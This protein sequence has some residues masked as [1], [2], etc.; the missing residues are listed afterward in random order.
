MPMKVII[1]P[2]RKV[3]CWPVHTEHGL[4]GGDA[5][6]LSRG[7][8]N[9]PARLPR[10]QGGL[11][12]PA[13]GEGRIR[14]EHEAIEGELAL[15]RLEGPED[16][17]PSDVSRFWVTAEAQREPRQVSAGAGTGETWAVRVLPPYP[18]PDQ[19]QHP[20]DAVGHVG[21][22]VLADPVWSF[23]QTGRVIA[24]S[25]W[26]SQSARC[27]SL[28]SVIVERGLRPALLLHLAP[29][30][31]PRFPQASCR[32]RSRRVCVRPGWCRRPCRRSAAGRSW[33]AF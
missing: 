16:R 2:A 8:L 18:S 25:G 15:P 3:S 24:T 31:L 5:A 33:R 32:Q 7:G 17:E 4:H 21:A 9:V 13:L 12:G 23:R 29:G 11:G 22:V 27:L 14:A 28:N 26:S 6:R 20:H 10:E 30:Q 19:A 1:R